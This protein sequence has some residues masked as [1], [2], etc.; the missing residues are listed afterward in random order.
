MEDSGSHTHNG[1]LVQDSPLQVP[2]FPELS[3]HQ[4]SNLSTHKSYS[5]A[6]YSGAAGPPLEALQAVFV[7]CLSLLYPGITSK[8]NTISL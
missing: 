7:W 8:A 3:S 4:K 2:L 6:L 5:G 1:L